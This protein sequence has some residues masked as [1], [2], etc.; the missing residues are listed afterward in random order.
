MS[1]LC[2]WAGHT[3]DDESRRRL[4]ARMASALSRHDRSEIESRCSV[5]CAVAVAS[6]F[7]NAS[8]TEER[9]LLAAIV[10]RPEWNDRALA[11]LA[12]A[13]GHA[14]ALA[15]A[16]IARGPRVLEILG[17]TFALAVVREGEWEALIAV[18]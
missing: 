8:V 13:K 9:F 1:G 11:D 12:A 17:G 10:G 4:L 15:E 7:G 18:D 6:L 14:Q 16:Y 2:G 3:A 5:G